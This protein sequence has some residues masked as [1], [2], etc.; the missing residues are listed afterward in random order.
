[1]KTDQKQSKGSGEPES[2]QKQHEQQLRAALADWFMG[3]SE[4][5]NSLGSP[6][7]VIDGNGVKR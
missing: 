7:P 5:L 6:L 4:P 2:P 1:M 3:I